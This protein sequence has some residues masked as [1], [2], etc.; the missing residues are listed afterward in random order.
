[1]QW[2]REEL[3]ADALRR[4]RLAGTAPDPDV[5]AK[6]LGLLVRDGGPDCDG[7][8]IG[9]RI[10]VSETMRPTRRA[11][12]IAHELGHWLQR[13]AGL[14]DTEASADYIAAALM[15]PIHPFARDLD[16]T[17]WDL[18]QLHARFR[19]ASFEAIARRIVTL[20]D[21]RAVIFDRPLSGTPRWSADP[22]DHAP[23][24]VEVLAADRALATG[25][26]VTPRRGLTAWPLI[27]HD[28]QRVIVVEAA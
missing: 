24:L 7:V 8:L 2:E 6:R 27:E 1:M 4:T 11:F 22:S 28:W 26:P 3:A 10:F 9:D 20:R 21:A 16:S 23:M 15:M 25:A 17:G 5:I 19:L 14:P 12:T 13:E 18:L